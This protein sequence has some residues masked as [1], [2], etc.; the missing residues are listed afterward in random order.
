ME[1]AGAKNIIN[2]FKLINISSIYH[3]FISNSKK[4][5]QWVFETKS[6]R[7]M[8]Y[9]DHVIVCRHHYRYRCLRS[10]RNSNRCISQIYITKN[11]KILELTSPHRSGKDIQLVSS[12]VA[13]QVKWCDASLASSF[14]DRA[15]RILH[16]AHK[17]P[18]TQLFDIW[19]HFS[20]M[21]ICH[22]SW[23]NPSSHIFKQF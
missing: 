1:F 22:P 15:T 11:P 12:V 19:V 20:D 5:R 3:I 21:L 10:D 16:F 18:T 17:F 8:Y 6:I 4:L 23:H 13:Y 7:C 9:I 14:A 2:L